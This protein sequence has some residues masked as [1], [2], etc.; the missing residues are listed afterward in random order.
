MTKFNLKTEPVLEMPLKIKPEREDN[1]SSEK[2]SKVKEE[3]I[4]KLEIEKNG[5]SE[6]ASKVKEE[7][8]MK[9][10]KETNSSS[11]KASKVKVGVCKDL[12]K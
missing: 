2:V 5:S 1:G 9:V 11:E 8:I 4:I 12:P 10:E 6:K 7:K 3:K